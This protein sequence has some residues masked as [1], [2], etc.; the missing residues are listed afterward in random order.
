MRPKRIAVTA[1]SR[2]FVLTVARGDDKPNPTGPWTWTVQIGEQAHEM[3]LKPE[4]EGNTLTRVML[5]R[6]GKDRY[7][8]PVG[9]D[10]SDIF[11]LMSSYFWGP[12]SWL[13]SPISRHCS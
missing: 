8:Y 2:H 1:L 4:L 9:S 6:D 11:M 13:P 7:G 3:M 12:M 5:G 10:Y